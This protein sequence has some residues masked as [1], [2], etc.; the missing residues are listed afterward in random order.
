MARLRTNRLSRDV[1][2]HADAAQ[3]AA[4]AAPLPRE[5]AVDHV[6][7]EAVV[8]R[9][10]AHGSAADVRP[11]AIAAVADERGVLDAQA[12]AAHEDRAAAAAVELLA[13]GVP[14]GEREV[15]DDQPR[16]GLVLAMGGREHLGGIAGVHV[17]DAPRPA[18]LSVT[19]PPPSRT[20]SR[21]ELRTLAV[22]RIRI[23]TGLGPQENVILPP[24]RTAAT[25]AEEVQLRAVPRPITR[26]D[27]AAGCT[28]AN[29]ADET[30]GSGRDD[31]P[32]VEAGPTQTTSAPTQA[33]AT[34]RRPIAGMFRGPGP[35]AP[36]ATRE[37][38]RA[39]TRRPGAAPCA[40]AATG[41]RAVRPTRRP[42]R[43][44][45]SRAW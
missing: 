23:V 14:V 18:P 19:D 1:P 32:C 22:A 36:P 4:V 45:R 2:G 42:G 31:D 26:V 11:V 5:S 3:R 21:R 34:A 33:A 25:T 9:Q 13:G 6:D 12:P 39:P 24:A 35:G 30:P 27:T 43:R 17:Q 15:L 41:S 28:A 7:R 44:V 29:G 10:R 38:R 16:R 20:T 8:L 37:P 40:L